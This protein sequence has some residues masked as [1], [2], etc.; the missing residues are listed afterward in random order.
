[1]K[2]ALVDGILANLE[3]ALA[4]IND[5]IQG[6]DVSA[7]AG[8]VESAVHGADA[9][10]RSVRR[11]VAVSRENNYQS[12]KSLK[13]AMRNFSVRG[14]EHRLPFER[15]RDPLLQLPP[16]GRP[17]GGD[18]PKL[19]AGAAGARRVVRRRHAPHTQPRGASCPLRPPERPRCA[20]SGRR[21]VDRSDRRALQPQDKPR[22]KDRLEVRVRR[23]TARG[24]TRCARRGRGVERCLQSRDG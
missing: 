12:S 8:G 24:P 23:R 11:I 7:L 6:V 22:Q 15:V 20:G 18:A 16:L 2:V 21:Q 5:D 19:P 1:M 17:A 9:T 3:S 14:G 10:L 13:T 4:E